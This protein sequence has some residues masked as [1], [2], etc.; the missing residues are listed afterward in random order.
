[1]GREFGVCSLIHTHSD[2]LYASNA[3]GAMHLAR[4]F[5]P[6]YIGVYL[7][8]S[9]LALDGEP[10][11][12]AVAMAGDYLRAVGVKAVRH[13]KSPEPGGPRFVVRWCALEE[14][15]VDWP[16][17]LAA[18]KAVGKDVPFSFHGEYSQHGDFDQLRPLVSRDVAYLRSMVI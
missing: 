4:G 10:W 11:P 8:P 2:A 3:S 7:D 15:L 16:Q 18:L 6:K 9:H 5:D 12:M 13:E 17:A 14:G 1:M